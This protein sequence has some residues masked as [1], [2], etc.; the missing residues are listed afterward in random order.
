MVV[1]PVRCK[2]DNDLTLQSEIL[3]GSITI[4]D[5]ANGNIA[6][7]PNGSG[8]V[9]LDGLSWPTADGSANQVLKTDGSGALTWTDVSSTISGSASTIQKL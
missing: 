4:T 9:Q 1:Q 5:G 8:A 6:I 3:P 2:R 7:S